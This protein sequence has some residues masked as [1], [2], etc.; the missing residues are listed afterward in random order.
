MIVNAARKALEIAGTGGEL[1]TRLH[2]NAARM[3]GGLE[4]VGFKLK[5]GQHPILPIMLGDAAAARHHASEA[6]R[7]YDTGPPEAAID[8][9]IQ[10]IEAEVAA[11]QAAGKMVT[12]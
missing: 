5:P 4:A 6:R 8:A 1:R 12:V 3:R 9:F 2:A 7:I 10:R 11:A